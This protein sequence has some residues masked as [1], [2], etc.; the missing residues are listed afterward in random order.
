MVVSLKF[1]IYVLMLYY[2]VTKKNNGVL[3]TRGLNT[4][5]KKV[6]FEKVVL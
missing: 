3:T 4:V 2:Q 1:I 5:L 6:G